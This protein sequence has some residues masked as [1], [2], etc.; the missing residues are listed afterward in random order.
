V[1]PTQRFTLPRC[2]QLALAFEVGEAK[3]HFPRPPGAVDSREAFPIIYLVRE[4][5]GCED[6]R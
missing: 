1:S 2:L 4:M 6:C 5:L 3:C